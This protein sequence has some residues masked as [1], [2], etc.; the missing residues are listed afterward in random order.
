MDSMEKFSIGLIV[1]SLIIVTPF[2]LAPT[3]NTTMGSLYNGIRHIP[4]AFFIFFVVMS[5]TFLIS[6]LKYKK[7]FKSRATYV[8]WLFSFVIG[9]FYTPKLFSFGSTQINNFFEA[10]EYTETY[11]VYMSREP[12]TASRRMVYKLPAKI[13]R[14]EYSERHD[15]ENFDYS[16]YYINQ[17]YF[18][19]GGYLSFD[20]DYAPLQLEKEVSVLDS[21]GDFYYITLTSEKATNADLI[22]SNRK[23]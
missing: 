10:D 6:I 16:D 12:E 23:D 2:I 14:R 13:E 19:N 22:E 11:Y 7:R 15:G 17:L 9:L 18:S 3:T 5:I 8:F 4:Q 21:C 20:D 1:V